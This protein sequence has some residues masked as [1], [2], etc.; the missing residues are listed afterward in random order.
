MILS[1]VILYI[2]VIGQQFEQINPLISADKHEFRIRPELS[3]IIIEILQ[4]SKTEIF[5]YYH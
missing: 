2:L 3:T 1:F 5:F 4:E